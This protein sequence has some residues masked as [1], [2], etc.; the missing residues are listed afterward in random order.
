MLAA[1]L[2]A[3]VATATP[4]ASPVPAPLKTI[5]SVKSSPFCGQ[6]ATHVN[7]AITSAITN[8]ATL[9]NVV[10]TLKRPD[11]DGTALDRQAEIDRLNS[12][13]DSIYH[14]YRSGEAEV[15]H[16]RELAQQ[17]TDPQ[18]KAELKDAADALAGALYRQHLIQRDLDGFVAYLNAADMNTYSDAQKSQNEALFGEPDPH[19]A[20]LDT[21]L[22]ARIGT[23][24]PPFT[25]PFGGLAGSESPADDEHFAKTAADDFVARFTPLAGDEMKAATHIEALSS[26]C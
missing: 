16:L 14:Q 2:A 25:S 24:A 5:A 7:A 11:L 21:D 22:H 23:G 9:G 10:A 18:E 20:A 13:A 19:Q 15:A 3:A 1:I 8:D 26:R 17:T 6:F 4:T 12:L